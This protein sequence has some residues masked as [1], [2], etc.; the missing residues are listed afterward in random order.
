M[1]YDKKRDYPEKYFTFIENI[2]NMVK[3]PYADSGLNDYFLCY[4]IPS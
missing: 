1:I 3:K 2:A 4:P